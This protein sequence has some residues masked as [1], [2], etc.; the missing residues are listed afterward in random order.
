MLRTLAKDSVIYLS[1]TIVNSAIPFLLLPILTRYLDTAEYGAIAMFQTLMG[2]LGA[3]VGVNVAGAA[4]RKY[5][6]NNITNNEMKDFIA[7]CLQIIC[8]SGL[9]VLFVILFFDARISKE[10]SIKSEW[11][12]YSVFSSAASMVI[13][14]RLRQW[15]VRKKPKHYGLFQV[16]QSSFNV[17]LSL[18]LVVI[19]SQGSEGRIT[20]Q[21]AAFGL[22]ASLALIFLKRDQIFG[23]FTWKPLYLKEALSFGLPLIPHV[24]GYFLLSSVDRFV[25]NERLG[26]S[27][28]GIYMAAV[29]ISSIVLLF[30]DAIN[31][32]YVPWL[33]ERPNKGNHE[34]KRL[35]VRYTYLWYF[36]ILCA[37]A[38]AFAFGPKLLI[39]IAS[40]KYEKAGAVIGWLVLGHGFTGMYLMV[41]NYIFYSKR[42]GLLS[43]VTISSGLINVFLLFSLIPL[44]GLKGAGMAFSISTGLRFILTWMVSQKIYPMPWFDFKR[45]SNLC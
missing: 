2:A 5:F 38:A 31:N 35:I 36:L 25:I 9:L 27:E 7:A 40:D 34:E 12:Y 14:L 33:Y 16:S 43:L 10:L 6:D 28:A 37:V 23:F 45:R 30:L 44:Y 32:A 41:T 18:Y 26:L 21:I 13:Q 39:I 1:A 29:Q 20:A 24:G 17:I 3:I 8:I 4:G 42:T 11:I 19:L 15:Q 22:F